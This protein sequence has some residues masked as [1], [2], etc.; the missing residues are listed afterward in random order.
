MGRKKSPLVRAIGIHR[1]NL[2]A[3]NGNHIIGSTQ[4][5]PQTEQRE[6]GLEHKVMMRK[7]ALGFFETITLTQGFDIAPLQII[8]RGRL[9]QGI[10]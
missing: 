9:A 2:V 7:Q 3:R 10:A 4:K 8:T 5:S 1:S 6:L